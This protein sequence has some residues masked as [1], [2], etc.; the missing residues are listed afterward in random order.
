[1]DRWHSEALM[2]DVGLVYA[3]FRVVCLVFWEG[4]PPPLNLGFSV[5]VY[6]LLEAVICC[7]VAV[8]YFSTTLYESFGLRCYGVLL[9]F[10]WVCP[11][12]V[13]VWEVR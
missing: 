7:V 2:F 4:S 6:G 9:S 12:W 3:H 1:M 10:L 8:L 13:K 5:S 11:C